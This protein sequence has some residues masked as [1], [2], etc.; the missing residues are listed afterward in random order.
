MQLFAC[1]LNNY[2]QLGV[3]DNDN[4]NEPTEVLDL[5][6][7]SVVDVQAGEHHTVVLTNRGVV[8]VMGRGDQGQLGVVGGAGDK[9]PVGQCVSRP[10]P[11]APARF[12]GA[13]S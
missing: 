1:G 9:I 5:D 2:G 4:R 12:G 6:G 10:T 8:F 7:A 3:G 11:I 13:G